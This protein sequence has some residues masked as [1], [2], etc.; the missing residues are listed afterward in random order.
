MAGVNGVNPSKE[1]HYGRNVALGATSGAAIGGVAGYALT[2]GATVRDGVTTVKPDVFVKAVRS[3]IEEEAKNVEG[4]PEFKGGAGE[5]INETL[6]ELKEGDKKGTAAIR[7]F[8]R[9]LD[10]DNVLLKEVEGEVNPIADVHRALKANKS[11]QLPEGQLQAAVD[12]INANT[13]ASKVNFLKGL[14]GNVSELPEVQNA[15]KEGATADEIADALK[16]VGRYDAPASKFTNVILANNKGLSEA[17]SNLSEVATDEQKTA[18]MEAYKNA[19]KA[20]S[21]V[22]IKDLSEN[23]DEAFEQIKTAFKVGK[24]NIDGT[25]GKGV[26]SAVE[27]AFVAG[28]STLR[29]T[30]EELEGLAKDMFGHVQKAVKSTKMKGALMV[31]AAAAFVGAVAGFVITKVNANKK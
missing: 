22:E 18:V 17:M 9:E 3:A 19:L 31:G 7:A 30:G 13:Q 21:S 24:E 8:I 20:D 15:L 16:A 4:L 25:N 1:N 29:K 14:T 5:L 10:D 11:V 26:K 23:A 12:A 27:E 2:S 28:K 6:F